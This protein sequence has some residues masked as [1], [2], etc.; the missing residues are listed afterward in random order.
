[1]TSGRADSRGGRPLSQDAERVEMPAHIA[2]A[3]GREDLHARL[4]DAGLAALLR[5]S[6]LSS[7]ASPVRAARVGRG[8]VAVERI[9][10]DPAGHQ[11]HR[12]AGAGMRRAAGEIEAAQVGAAIA[13]LERAEEFPVAGEAVDRAVRARGSGRGCPAA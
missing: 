1:M 12:H 7:G 13:G 9:G 4:G 8:S 10:G 6:L 3:V 5:A 2:A 11:H